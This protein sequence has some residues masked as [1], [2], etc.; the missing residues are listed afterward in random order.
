MDVG[1]AIMLLLPLVL[2]VLPPL[3]PKPTLLGRPALRPEL[4]PPP[5]APPEA[6]AGVTSASSSNFRGV[7]AEV[8]LA[9]ETEADR[10][11]WMVSMFVPASGQ[12][13]TMRID[14]DSGDLLEQISAP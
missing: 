1:V 10:A 14:A 4:P 7:K 6:A 3:P 9:M 5:W 8:A 11:E 2:P 12:T 13:L